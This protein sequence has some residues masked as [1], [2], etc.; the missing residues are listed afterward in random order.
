MNKVVTLAL[1]FLC[2]SF[3]FA[4][5]EQLTIRAGL[6]IDGTGATSENVTIKVEDGIIQSIDNGAGPYDFD[7]SDKTVLPGLI[8]TH[9]HITAHFNSQGRYEP[10]PGQTPAQTLLYAAENA[11][12]T[13]MAGFTTIQ[14][15]GRADDKDLRDA[16]NRGI[17]PGPHILTSLAPVNVNSGPPQRLREIVQQHH[18]DGADVIKMFAS[19]SIRD[20]GHQVM[21]DD[22]I[23]AVC[24]TANELGLRTVVHAYGTESIATVIEA[25]CT[26]IEHG[27]RYSDD[28]IELMS[29][30]GTYYDPHLGL[31]YANY[32]DN[33]GKFI[34]I[35]NYTEEG[36]AAMEEARSIGYETFKRTLELGKVKIVY[37]T[38]ALAG[39][40][41]R[42]IEELI[43]RVTEGGQ[44]IMEAIV[45]ATSLAAE[46]LR[47][48]TEIG[49]VASGYNADI[50]A[51]DGNPLQD[52][53]ALRNVRFVMKDGSV[54]K[55]N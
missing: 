37:G 4:Q 41:G 51:I 17:L 10:D 33:R 32:F 54:H 55:N 40:H 3:S 28:I 9:V 21:S 2:S 11:Y 22:Q 42:N 18:E 39:A 48:D 5:S 19:A 53:T 14:S 26:Q 20:G 34:G 46:S 27:N 15:V 36:Y 24:V 45:S 35:G 52:V 47:M 43:Y 13:L 30:T 6:L 25:G 8:D 16:I 12:V 7:F 1:L 38:D 44:G 50:I 31:L 23:E 49:S 29:E